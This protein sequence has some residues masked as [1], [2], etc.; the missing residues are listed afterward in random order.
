M[1]K[2][3]AENDG[4][5]HRFG[6]PIIRYIVLSGSFRIPPDKRMEGVISTS[7]TLHNNHI[8]PVG[9]RCHLTEHSW[10]VREHPLTYNPFIW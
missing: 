3:T 2:F 7:S 10:R 1:Q 8:D 4:Q 6:G 9:Y 5:F